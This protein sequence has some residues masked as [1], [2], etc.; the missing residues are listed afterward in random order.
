MVVMWCYGYGFYVIGDDDGG[1]V[2][3]DL[4]YVE[5]YG[6]EFWVVKLV[7]VL[8]GCFL[9]DVG[10]Y[11]CLMCGILVFVGWKYLVYDDFVDFCS[12]DVCVFECCFDGC[13]V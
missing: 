5:C 9:W 11:G 2:C 3:G 6:V 7:E 13:C 1:V 12:G 4:L 10:F 8:G